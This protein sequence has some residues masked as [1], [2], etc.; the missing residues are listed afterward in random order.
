MKRFFGYQ[1]YDHQKILRCNS[2]S[3]KMGFTWL[4]RVLWIRNILKSKLNSKLEQDLFGL[5]L[6]IGLLLKIDMKAEL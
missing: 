4:N 3:N 6:F 1:T 5:L 2:K